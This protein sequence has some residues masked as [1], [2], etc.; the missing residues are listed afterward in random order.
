[1]AVGQ[2]RWALYQCMLIYKTA[3]WFDMIFLAIL[4]DDYW[5]FSGGML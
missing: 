1:V 4:L 2:G 5:S 3:F